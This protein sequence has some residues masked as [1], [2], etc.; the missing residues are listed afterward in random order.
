MFHRVYQFIH[1]STQPDSGMGM[2][3]SASLFLEQIIPGSE[4]SRTP[5]SAEEWFVLSQGTGYFL[6][7]GRYIWRNGEGTN[8]EVRVVYTNRENVRCLYVFNH[9]SL[10][11]RSCSTRKGVHD[12]FGVSF[13]VIPFSLP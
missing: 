3:V 6:R 2:F 1:A 9:L 11:G 12:I 13:C 10:W 4:R 8:P 7:N 5:S